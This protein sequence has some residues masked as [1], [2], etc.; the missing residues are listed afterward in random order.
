MATNTQGDDAEAASA[1]DAEAASAAADD[2]AAVVEQPFHERYP[3]V[4][5]EQFAAWREAF[6]VRVQGG[7]HRNLKTQAELDVI[8]DLLQRWDELNHAE[9]RGISAS[10]GHWKTKYKL[11][12]PLGNSDWSLSNIWTQLPCQHCATLGGRRL[13]N[14][15]RERWNQLQIATLLV[16]LQSS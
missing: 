15:R 16:L 14:K 8:Q 11:V 7:K 10:A 5:A 2:G 4:S 1:A 6:N 9:R 3:G 12:V 13:S